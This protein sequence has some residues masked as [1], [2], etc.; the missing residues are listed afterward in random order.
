MSLSACLPY[1][2]RA[3]TF[4]AVPAGQFF[5]IYCLCLQSVVSS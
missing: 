4:G 3:R 5:I 1:H 2:G